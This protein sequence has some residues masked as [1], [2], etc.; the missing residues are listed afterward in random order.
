MAKGNYGVNALGGVANAGSS[1]K[2]TSQ[3][4]E[5][6]SRVGKIF[7]ETVANNGNLPNTFFERGA[8]TKPA[9]S[10]ASQ[11]QVVAEIAKSYNSQKNDV[12]TTFLKHKKN[13]S[14]K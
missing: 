8:T 6:S 4:G 10:I 14:D 12:A 3:S 11:V 13:K 5:R 1:G 9:K 7:T 2:A